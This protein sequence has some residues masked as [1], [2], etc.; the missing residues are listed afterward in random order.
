MFVHQAVVRFMNGASLA[1]SAATVSKGTISNPPVAAGIAE[2]IFREF[3]CDSR[4][5][6]YPVW[7]GLERTLPA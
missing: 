7:V 3:A 2:R 1:T 6:R 4:A 5:V